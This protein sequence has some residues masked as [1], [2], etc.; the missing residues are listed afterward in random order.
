MLNPCRIFALD[1]W[2]KG[3]Y[4]LVQTNKDD[5]LRKFTMFVLSPVVILTKATTWLFRYVTFSKE[6]EAI[7]CIQVVHGFVLNGSPL[8]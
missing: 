5:T 1:V 2:P 4:Q 7:R 8:K 3:Y 6:E